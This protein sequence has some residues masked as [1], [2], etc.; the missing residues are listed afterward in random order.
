MILKIHGH[1]Q[2]DVYTGPDDWPLPFSKQGHWPGAD[3]LMT[4][5]VH[6]DV[7]FPYGA[8]IG[9]EPFDV[10]FTIKAFMLDGR[11]GGPVSEMGIAVKY[12]ATGTSTPPVMQGDPTSMVPKVW[13]G[14]ITIDPQKGRFAHKHGWTHVDFLART[15]FTNGD[16]M[17][18]KAFAPFFSVFDTS[19]PEDLPP[20]NF[21]PILSS[22]VDVTSKRTG[23]KFGTMV[24]E[25]E[26]WIPLLPIDAPWPLLVSFY[27][28]AT[29]SDDPL[30]L[31]RFEESFNVNYHAGI[32]GVVTDATVADK[33][34]QTREVVIDPAAMGPG[35]HNVVFRWAQSIG[36]EHVSSLVVIN[37]VVG[38]AV[39]PSEKVT[40]PNLVGLTA[41]AAGALLGTVGLALGMSMSANDPKVPA[42]S[43]LSQTPAAGTQVVKG[44]AVNL[45][46][47]AGPVAAPSEV[48]RMVT[49]KFMQLVVNGVP[50]DRFRICDPDEPMTDPLACPEV[51][52][53]A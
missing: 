25:I 28:Y 21:G 8:E 47:S 36:D 5:H 7:R 19:V 12:D 40:V 31:G 53:K 26:N 18:V 43:V 6:M 52:T 27:N 14:V 45:L 23:A 38:D 4:Q 48:W 34:G 46:V 17:D 39:P 30:S 33:Q 10:P 20:G 50:Q 32:Y 11:V 37:T 35:A 24:T 49:P 29:A 41:S 2:K 15:E 3:P 9:A 22:R 16:Q 13:T 1:P 51:V 42:G 44:S